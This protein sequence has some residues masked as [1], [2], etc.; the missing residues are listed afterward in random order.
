MT[1]GDGKQRSGQLKVFGGLVVIGT[2]RMKNEGSG[3]QRG[4]ESFI[5]E[6]SRA[7]AEGTMGGFSPR[8]SAVPRGES[9][10]V[11]GLATGRNRCH[12]NS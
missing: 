8:Q 10:D 12:V 4:A 3:E 2:E 6:E 11:V 1:N 9:V 5:T 7:A